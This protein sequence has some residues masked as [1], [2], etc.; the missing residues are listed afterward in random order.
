LAYDKD[1]GGR[2]IVSFE[3]KEF[4]NDLRLLTEF[5]KDL[6]EIASQM[7]GEKKGG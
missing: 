1:G 4:M 3:S 5:D 2:V 7:R 6:L